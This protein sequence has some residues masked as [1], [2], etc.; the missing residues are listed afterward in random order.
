VQATLFGFGDQRG[1]GFAGTAQHR[2][3]RADVRMAA[4]ADGM[5]VVIGEE[6]LHVLQADRT[7]LLVDQYPQPIQSWK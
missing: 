2:S 1:D 6:V 7:E 5:A 3:A 4:D